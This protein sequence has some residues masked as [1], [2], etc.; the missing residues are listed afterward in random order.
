MFTKGRQKKGSRG[1][2][3]EQQANLWMNNIETKVVFEG[4]PADCWEWV[5]LGCKWESTK[6]NTKKRR[7]LNI[8]SECHLVA[9]EVVHFCICICIC[10]NREWVSLGCKLERKLH[11]KV[12]QPTNQPLCEEQLPDHTNANTIKTHTNASQ[13]TDHTN[14]NTNRQRPSSTDCRSYPPP[15]LHLAKMEFFLGG[16]G[17][18]VE[19]KNGFRLPLQAA[20]IL[21]IPEHYHCKS[22]N[23]FSNQK[24]CTSTFLIKC[25][26]HNFPAY[27]P[28]LWGAC[29]VWIALVCLFCSSVSLLPTICTIKWHVTWLQ[30]SPF[31]CLWVAVVLHINVDDCHSD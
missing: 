3:D 20:S 23:A 17:G 21:A 19:Y 13:I 31:W 2:N 16:W 26:Q 4:A 6:A 28:R 29:L 24:I 7:R 9:K 18:I 11:K 25:C 8:G 10:K 27:S 22:W 15:T 14:I 1:V 5:S 12:D 30:S